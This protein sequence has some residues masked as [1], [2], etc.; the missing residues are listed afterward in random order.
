MNN[1]STRVSPENSSGIFTG[2]RK[3]VPLTH[4][5][6]LAGSISRNLILGVE[7]RF[8]MDRVLMP[9]VRAME[10]LHMGAQ[11]AYDDFHHGMTMDEMDER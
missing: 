4:I 10:S 6:I 1:V 5:R 3:K 9:L 8:Q 11:W 7:P 2:N